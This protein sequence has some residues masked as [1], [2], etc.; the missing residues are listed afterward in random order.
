MPSVLQKRSWG[1]IVRAGA[2][3]TLALGA[4]AVSA[5]ACLDR[6]IEPVEPRTTSTI[7]EQLRQSKVD[8]IDML[9]IIDN[10]RSMADKQSILKD[11]VPS[12]VAQLVNPK[13]LQTD[14]NGNVTE[15]ATQPASPLQD[16][17]AG[18]EREFEPIVDFHIGVLT[19]SLGGHG[20]DA[21]TAQTEPS[22]DDHGYLINRID[23]SG[24]SPPAATYNDGSQDLKFLVWDPNS[25]APTH[26]P[27]GESDLGTLAAE[28][29]KMV[30]G[31]GEVG[32]GFEAQLE[33]WYRFLIDPVPHESVTLDGDTAE[34]QGEDETLLNMRKNF[35]RP[36]SLLAIVM[37]TDEN[38]CSIRD[39]SQYYFAAQIYTPGS[40]SAYHLP[41]ARN[42]CASDPNS[43]C[44]RSCGQPPADGCDAS[45]DVCDGPLAEID[46]KVNLRCFDQKRRFGIDFLNPISRYTDGLTQS[47]VNDRDGN[48]VAN[49]IFSDLQP[50][51][52]NNNIRDSSLVFVAGIVGVPWQ[53]IARQ[54]EAGDPDLLAGLNKAGEAVGGFKSGDELQLGAWDTI[55]GD[56][57]CYHTNV[58]CLPDDPLMLESVEHRT[59]ANPVT[60]DSVVD[61]AS[62]LGNNI[63]GH[64]YDIPGRDDLQYACIFPIADKDCLAAGQKNC[65]CDAKS[66]GTNNPLCFNGTTYDNIQRKAKAYP[67]V[68][69][70]QVL[71][72]IG[73]QGIVGSI[74]PAQLDDSNK[75]ALDYGYNPGVQAIV[76]RLKLALG[77][78]CL[79]RSLKPN[80]EKQVS[81]LILE[82]RQG[83]CGG[84]EEP[85]RRV[86]GAGSKA[87]IDAAKEL[88]EGLDC[89]C[90]IVQLSGEELE[91]CQE[92]PSETI[93]V[94]SQPVD[95]WCYVD[96][97]TVPPIGHS[98]N[99]ASCPANQKR[100]IKFVG[101]GQGVI[102]STLFI[103]CTG[104]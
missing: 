99:V 12:M 17:E 59:G 22:E 7:V 52:N 102:G 75:L 9:L 33:A 46:D 69:E 40:N 87:A 39:G 60:G 3:A 56:P 34:L 98:D 103:T 84:C 11:A 104:E 8:K 55:L 41:N 35:L 29:G 64:E 14:E 58:E 51:D 13:C 37:L 53:D 95:G 31:A 65:D 18:F 6:P 88:N 42:A 50:D 91:A 100:K 5:P 15:Q 85:A 76:D 54:N 97:A 43:K 90:E 1:S 66:D 63:N 74:C 68:R 80:A 28:L 2:A 92:Q 49:P 21:C 86:P 44:C 20:S 77:G 48:L 83:D 70:L 79:P 27:Q 71:Q 10:S 72:A 61:S 45:N 89:F 94:N 82:G 73:T 93:S 25:G 57:S 4:L 26:S 38:D 30:S 16:C 24:M 47:K 78:Q 32:C 96:G 67:G 101:Q 19:S 36:D 23:T 62:P 81:C